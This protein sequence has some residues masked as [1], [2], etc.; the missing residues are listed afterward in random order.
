MTSKRSSTSTTA[1]SLRRTSSRG[2]LS[3]TPKS[4][5]PRAWD[6][7]PRSSVKA[8]LR[9][10]QRPLTEEKIVDEVRSVSRGRRARPNDGVTT[11]TFS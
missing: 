6:E 1:T 2:S 10:G 4:A 9:P 5:E 3:F 8:R 11:G 7:I